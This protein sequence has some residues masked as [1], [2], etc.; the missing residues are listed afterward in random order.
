MAILDS[1]HPVIV[2][3]TTSVE[4]FYHQLKDYGAQKFHIDKSDGFYTG[5]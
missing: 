3:D 5:T 2:G 4:Q 1:G